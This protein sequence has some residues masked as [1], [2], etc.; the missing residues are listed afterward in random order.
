[1]SLSTRLTIFVISRN[2]IF[3]LF[4]GQSFFQCYN[5]FSNTFPAQ[6]NTSCTFS[7][8]SHSLVSL[9]IF[10]ILSPLNS[11]THS[12]LRLPSF[13][14]LSLL[15]F[16]FSLYSTHLI[17]FFC[18]SV[19]PKILLTSSFLSLHVLFHQSIFRQTHRNLVRPT[20]GCRPIDPVRLSTE[21]IPI[22]SGGGSSGWASNFWSLRP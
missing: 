4:S 11:I 9:A 2:F 17:P 13:M 22:A 21:S 1:M 6:Q 3:P 7:L 8:F 14:S 10:S 16:S 19:A 5:K 12:F 15:L 18:L 20:L